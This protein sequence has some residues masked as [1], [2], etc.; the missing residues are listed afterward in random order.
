MWVLV[1]ILSVLYGDGEMD[2]VV[3]EI[4]TVA[5]GLGMWV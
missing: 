5:E 1:V 4:P 2:V 3:V